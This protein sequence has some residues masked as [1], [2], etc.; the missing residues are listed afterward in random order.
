MPLLGT[1]GS[2]SASGYGVNG[3][4]IYPNLR[5]QYAA[6]NSSVVT[7]NSYFIKP[8]AGAAFEVFGIKQ[9]SDLCTIPS[10]ASNWIKDVRAIE[11]LSRSTIGNVDTQNISYANFL[12]LVQEKQDLT[13]SGYTCYFYYIVIDN[14]TLWGATRTR[15]NNGF[16]TWR[17][18]HAGDLGTPNGL[19]DTV[20]AYWDAWHST[21]TINNIGPSAGSTNTPTG[22]V[23][24]IPYRNTAQFINSSS[25]YS[26]TETGLH[27]KREGFGEHYPWRNASDG[28]CSTL[29]YFAPPG[30]TAAGGTTQTVPNTA[31]GY[32]GIAIT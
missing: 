24:M 13:S 23:R 6:N 29:G 7:G 20:R 32:I 5:S 26:A 8:D 10:G 3:I 28:V 4:R 14:G 31:I 19:P 1:R 16:T 21:Y 22:I 27:Y 25:T 18:A 15:F 9:V 2:G 12:R 17:D 30:G 11:V